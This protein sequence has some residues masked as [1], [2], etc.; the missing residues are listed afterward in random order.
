MLDWWVVIARPNS[1][2]MWQIGEESLMLFTKLQWM[3]SLLL[4]VLRLKTVL[5][6]SMKIFINK[7][8]HQGFFSMVLFFPY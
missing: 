4:M 8:N 7:I 3:V 5:F 1:S 2:N 6:T